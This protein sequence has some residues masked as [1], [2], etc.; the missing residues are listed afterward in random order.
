MNESKIRSFLGGFTLVLGGS[1]I[2][3]MMGG[4]AVALSRSNIP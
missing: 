1:A 3:L 4:L 2:A